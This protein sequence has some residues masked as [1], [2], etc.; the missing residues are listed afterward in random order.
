MAQQNDKRPVRDDGLAPREVPYRA[1]QK[2]QATSKDSLLSGGP[3]TGF[4]PGHDYT[5]RGSSLR[6]GGVEEDWAS[7]Q[8]PIAPGGPRPGNGPRRPMP[9]EIPVYSTPAPG[10]TGVFVRHL[11]GHTELQRERP[12]LQQYH[13]SLD[14]NDEDEAGERAS[15]AAEIAH[16]DA[17]WTHK[18]W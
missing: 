8:A 3:G 7:K 14:P 9:R 11:D 18:Y 5:L 6:A 12:A 4:V 13:D 15:V 10:G 17:V 2:N 1:G 16:R